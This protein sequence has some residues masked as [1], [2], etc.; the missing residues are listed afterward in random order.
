MKHDIQSSPQPFG[1][2]LE[3]DKS[4][5]TGR[6]LYVNILTWLL[7]IV[8]PLA[9]FAVVNLF[10]LDDTKIG[11]GVAV[12]VSAVS[13]SSYM[14]FLNLKSNKKY[15]SQLVANGF[16][17][18]DG[19]SPATVEVYNNF[20]SIR[21]G[22]GVRLS[23][24]FANS[25]KQIGTFRISQVVGM[26]K[27]SRKR[28]AV[29]YARLDRSAPHIVFDDRQ[30]GA[31]VMPHKVAS[32]FT[33]VDSRLS[34]YDLAVYGE[35]FKY[36]RAYY[37]ST[38]PNSATN[39]INVIAKQHHVWRGFEMEVCGNYIF[40]VSRL[41]FFSPVYLFDCLEKLKQIVEHETSKD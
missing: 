33:G 40:V 6:S 3:E 23:K 18:V 25:S 15:A 10:F 34:E 37:D 39:I 36:I 19:K 32:N 4:I 22:R 28:L 20:T 27:R 30:I 1:L 11:V 29:A 16:E 31:G 26:G 24:Q 5:T 35:D 12:L 9:V 21:F 14:A 17:P 38:E 13:V 7:V 2:L 8:W 41:T